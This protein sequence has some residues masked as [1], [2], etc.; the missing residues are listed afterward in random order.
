MKALVFPGQGAQF[1]G[2]GKD[3]YELSNAS[4]VI[5]DAA[6]TILGFKLSEVMF[7]GTAEDLKQ[8]KITQPA[9][10]VHAIATFESKD[11]AQPAAVAGHSLGEF[12]ALVA[13]KTLTFEDGLNLV[14]QRAL[15]MQMACEQV[16]GTMAAVLGMED[17]MVEDICQ[18]LSNVVVVAANYN[19]P[20]QLVISGSLEGIDAAILAL[21]NAGAKRAIK[22]EVGGAFHSPLME[23]AKKQLEDAILTTQFSKP[24]CP[25]YQNVNGQKS[26]DPDIIKQ[27]LIAQLTGPVKWTQT[28]QNMFADGIDTFTEVG[29]T[30]KVL[31]G[32]IKKTEK[33]SIIE[34]F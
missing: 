11:T 18:S 25:I 17:K 10:F 2:M 34:P 12:S 6:D 1:E 33:E 14:Y 27:N 9:L 13:N 30:G 3:L 29:G 32:L 16:P 5:F 24:I 8:T 26:T 20:G 15:A 7:H 19:C 22:L 4:K 28:I 31:S 23:P 21:Q